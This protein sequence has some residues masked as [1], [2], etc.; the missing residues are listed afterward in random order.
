[1]GVC[2]SQERVQV[3]V[4][5]HGFIMA[6][7]RPP[8]L[9]AMSDDVYA[10][11]DDSLGTKGCVPAQSVV[12]PSHTQPVRRS[13]NA[14]RPFLTRASDLPHRLLYQVSVF[15]VTELT[16]LVLPIENCFR[17]AACSTREIVEVL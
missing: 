8:K 10:S 12:L 11:I 17:P 13:S 14:S 4:E 7:H 3:P 9:D 5:R 15:F 6:G 1:M 16:L 2:V